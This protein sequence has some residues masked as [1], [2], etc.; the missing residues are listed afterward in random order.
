MYGYAGK[1]G[2]VDLTENTHFTIATEESL[3]KNYLGG[4]GFLIK[5]LYDLMPQGRNPL[6]PE[7]I[8]IFVAG[9]LNGTLAPTSGRLMVGGKS[10]ATGILSS[11][12]CGG[13]LGAKLKWAGFDAIIIKGRAKNPCYLMVKNDD[14]EIVSAKDLWGK[15]TS[16]T[17]ELIQDRHKDP[18]IRVACIGV[19]GENMVP[20]ASIFAEKTHHGGRAGMGAVMGSKNLKALAING[21]KGVKIASTKRLI[22]ESKKIIEMVMGESHYPMYT[23]TGSCKGT[24]LYAELGGLSAYNAQSGVFKEF[25]KINSDNFFKYKLE[26]HTRACFACPM[27]CFHQFWV[28]EGKYAGTFGSGLQNGTIQCFGTKIGNANFEALLAFHVASNKYGLDGISLGV[29]IAFA[30]EC[31]QKNII[32]EKDAGGLNLEWGNEEAISELSRM[33]AYGE[34][35]GKI[36]GQ[37]V[38]KAADR[39][40]GGSEKFALHVKNLEVSTVDARIMPAC[41]LQYAVSS[42]GAHHMQA[43]PVWEWPGVIDDNTLIKIGGTTAITDRFTTEGKGKGVAYSENARAITDSLQMC[44]TFSRIKIGM[45]E[46]TFGLLQAVTGIDWTEP[47][48]YQ[49]GERINNLERLFNLREGLKPSDDTLPWRFLNEPIPDGASKG[50]ITNLEP[51]LDDYYAARGWSREDGYPIPEKLDELEKQAEG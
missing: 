22:Q 42:R 32:T 29:A 14:I 38:K 28:P 23:T 15:D 18:E 12:N 41:A 35:I 36:L 16:E 48:L 21:N 17:E 27:A 24:T 31:Y 33:I 25:D 9:P 1:I 30:M 39:F 8:L 11:G 37:G 34:G 45:P 51:M 10:P 13:F 49:I 6:G 5:L 7:S 44:K 19:A 4:R 26:G 20:M 43:Y 47:Q 46:T 50:M 3:I 2:V 40:G